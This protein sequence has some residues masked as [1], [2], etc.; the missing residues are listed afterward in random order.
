MNLIVAVDQEWGIG[1]EGD[2]LARVR[3]DLRLFARLTRGKVLVYGS[4]TLAT[5]PNGE[6]L[7]GRTN[8]ILH[9]SKDF[10]VEGAIIA[11]SLDHL[12]EILKEYDKDDVFVIGG[13]SVYKQLLPYCHRAYITKFEKSFD[14]DTYIPNL[15]EDE[16]WECV[17]LSH[18]YKTD[19]QTD[20]GGD[21]S[22]RYTVYE[23]LK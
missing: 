19:P 18:E 13:A 22:F 1:Y 10:K 2:L 11:N 12:F 17:S 14:K 8:I 7:K 20:T 4:N 15:D 23:R 5:F 16:S 6:V 21:F 9:P 3:E